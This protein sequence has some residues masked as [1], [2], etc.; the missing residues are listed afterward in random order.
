MY[1]WSDV[2][3]YDWFFND[4]ME[5]TNTLMQ[6]AKPLI[7]GIS[8]KVFQSG[9]PAFYVE[10][11]G[12]SGRRTFTIN[13]YA[14]PTNENPLNVFVD[15]VQ[16]QYKAVT[17]DATAG[18]TTIEMYVAP[19]EGSIV[20]FQSAG[21]AEVDRFGQPIWS[22]DASY[23]PS[24]KLDYGDYYVYD[25][26]ARNRGEYLWAFGRMLKRAHITPQEWASTPIHDLI[27]KHIGMVPDVYAI[28]PQG[29]IY[30]PY[31]LNGVTCRLQY[32][33]YE[34]GN[35]YQ[36]GGTFQ[37]YSTSTT[38]TYNNKFFPNALITR[39]EAYTL[40]SRLRDTLYARFSDQD[41]P[42]AKLDQTIR[43][44]TGQK[45]IRLN[46][47]YPAGTGQLQVKL[48]GVVMYK[49]VHYT[50]F[51]NHTILWKTPLE[52][53]QMVS[54][55]YEKTAST[56]F[57]D[58]GHAYNIYNETDDQTLSVGADA[59]WKNYIL[60]MEDETFAD[61]SY[62]INGLTPNK[63]LDS[64][65]VVTDQWYRPAWGNQATQRWFMGDAVLTRAEAVTFLN[66]FRKWCLERFK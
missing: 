32:W 66:R 23:Y 58:V 65:T 33:S 63:F 26:F 53:G 36:R 47:N 19:P 45:V 15:G 57:P 31:N 51:D 4:V 6:D 44:Y 5:A 56:R 39:A 61:G 24:K 54:V 14:I 35:Y 10:Q 8:Y 37:A 50:E 41:A 16:T 59:W 27:S 52:D 49:D 64:T 30:L 34:S 55:Y 11:N 21:I 2:T 48:D 28:S 25:P 42:G 3:Q 62:L 43:M 46:G 40:I 38:L 12:G 7:S 20:A 60:A 9:A 18:T 1:S 29:Y 13:K 22:G 17:Q